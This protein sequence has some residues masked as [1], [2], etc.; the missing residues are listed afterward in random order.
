MENWTRAGRAEI[1]MAPNT[2]GHTPLIYNTTSVT[3]AMR[4]YEYCDVE[5]VR[6]EVLQP[7]VVYKKKHIDKKPQSSRQSPG[8]TK[9]QP[10][11]VKI[12]QIS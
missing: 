5:P 7:I 6:D 10:K 11:Y 1:A 12:C 2:V 3:V 8:R 4:T 9:Y